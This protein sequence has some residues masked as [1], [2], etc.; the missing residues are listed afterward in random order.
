M[1]NC[2]TQRT[3]KR[4][5]DDVNN[6]KLQISEISNKERK[7]FSWPEHKNEPL[8]LSPL[9][10]TNT[11]AEEPNHQFSLF[12]ASLVHLRPCCS[13][14]NQTNSSSNSPG[15]WPLNWNPKFFKISPNTVWV[16]PHMPRYDTDTAVNHRLQRAWLPSGEH[17]TPQL[18][19]MSCLELQIISLIFMMHSS[20]I[21]IYV[22]QGLTSSPMKSLSDQNRLIMDLDQAG[23]IIHIHICIRDQN[24]LRVFQQ[25]FFPFI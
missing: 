3:I 15:W 21:Y 11:I 14:G 23:Q 4:S 7:L 9:Q 22:S 12:Q 17:C 8:K 1:N 2:F 6:H 5:V 25:L 13:L 20:H 19:L 18:M 16:I 24:L 10:H